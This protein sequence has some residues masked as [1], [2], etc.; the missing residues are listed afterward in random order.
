MLGL[1]AAAAKTSL[2]P[3]DIGFFIACG[4]IV[5]LI[6]AVYFLIPVFNKKQYQEQRD[7]LHKREK[8]FRANQQ[9]QGEDVADQTPAQ[10]ETLADA[11]VEE[12]A[13]DKD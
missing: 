8:A 11:T 5:V 7:N 10:D 9:P 6:V 1:L 13:A 2:K 3:W 12:K 4:V